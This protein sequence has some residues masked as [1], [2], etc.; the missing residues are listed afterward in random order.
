MPPLPFCMAIIGASKPF[1]DTVYEYRL[2]E[3][4]TLGGDKIV[5]K[6][7]L[8]L[9]DDHYSQKDTSMNHKIWEL[10]PLSGPGTEEEVSCLMSTRSRLE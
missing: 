5:L 3:Q 1:G 10:I 4:R 9:T 8:P 6:N 7:R 2:D